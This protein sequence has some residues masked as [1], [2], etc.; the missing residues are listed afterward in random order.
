MLSIEKSKSL[1][2]TRLSFVPRKITYYKIF[3]KYC[4]FPCTLQKPKET[5]SHRVPC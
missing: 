2:V 5:F 4:S 3:T 1:N